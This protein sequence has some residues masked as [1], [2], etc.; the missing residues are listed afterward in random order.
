MNDLL[1]LTA[2]AKVEK[3]PLL[4]DFYILT[5]CVENKIVEYQLSKNALIEITSKLV[6]EA[7]L[8]KY[9]AKYPL[10]LDDPTP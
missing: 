3:H 10:A 7:M 6:P 9:R 8:A 1:E 2:Y 4:P 5:L